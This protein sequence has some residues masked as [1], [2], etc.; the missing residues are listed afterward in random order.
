[1]RKS[2][3]SN[4]KSQIPNGT[5]QISDLKLELDRL[6]TVANS[7]RDPYFLALSAAALLNAGQADSTRGSAGASP[8]RRTADG[9]RFLETLIQLQAIDGSLTGATTVTQSGGLSLTAETTSLAILAWL[10]SPQP[11]FADPAARAAK[12]IVSHRQGPGGFGSTQATVLALKAMVAYSR[13]G[14]IARRGGTLQVVRGSETLAQTTMPSGSESGTTIELTGIGSKLVAGDT[15]LELRAPS[16]GRL[17]FVID[18]AYHS[19]SP[20]SDPNCPLRLTTKLTSTELAQGDTARLEARLKNA[21]DRGLPMTVAI[22]GLPAGLEPRAEELNELREAGAFDFYELRSREVILYW[23]AI[24]PQ[25][26]HRLSLTLTA[27]I[28]GEYT[29]PASRSYLY[30]TAE[31]KQWTEPLRARIAR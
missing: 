6:T 9:E 25:A 14:T 26:E 5:S 23:R 1:M 20:P 19:P 10:K 27:T 24:A 22:L 3:I 30:Y 16:F 15:D 12:W 29:A 31:Q 8:S 7:S 21:T 28:P 11:R 2:E 18:V 4:P 17:P 13:T